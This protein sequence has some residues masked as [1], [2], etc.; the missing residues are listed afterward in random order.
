MLKDTLG[1]VIMVISRQKSTLELCM[2]GHH[3]L[4]S[5]SK[6]RFRDPNDF[7]QVTDNSFIVASFGTRQ[8]DYI[9]L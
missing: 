1:F 4:V 8:I 2:Q 7:E 9:L 6:D 5:A 3:Y